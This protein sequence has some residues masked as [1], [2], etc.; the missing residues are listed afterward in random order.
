MV[1]VPIREPPLVTSIRCKDAI[2][3]P[4]GMLADAILPSVVGIESPVAVEVEAGG[5]GFYAMPKV[6]YQEPALVGTL[7]FC[8]IAEGLQKRLMLFKTHYSI[9]EAT[10]QVEILHDLIRP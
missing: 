3:F 7:T 5:D 9:D 6:A 1:N 2:G 10:R 4:E 8:P